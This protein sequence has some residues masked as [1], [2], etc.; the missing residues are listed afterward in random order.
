MESAYNFGRSIK[1][2][3]FTSLSGQRKESLNYE[4]IWCN[5]YIGRLVGDEY[6]IFSEL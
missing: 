2:W 5:W 3:R 4:Q 6:E 1:M